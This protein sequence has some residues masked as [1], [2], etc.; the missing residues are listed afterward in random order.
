MSFSSNPFG[1]K[2][3]GLRGNIHAFGEYLAEFKQ[4]CFCHCEY[5]LSS[6]VLQGI[7]DEVYDIPTQKNLEP[8]ALQRVSRLTGAFTESFGEG[9]VPDPAKPAYTR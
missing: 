5:L 2:A 8:D 6:H 1:L 9:Q 3:S 7:L 4:V